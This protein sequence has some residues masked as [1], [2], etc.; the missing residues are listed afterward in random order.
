MHPTKKLKEKI[1]TLEERLDVYGM[2][3][4]KLLNSEDL[5]DEEFSYLANNLPDTV[6]GAAGE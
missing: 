2:V 5:T 4:Q 1:E 3:L 6:A